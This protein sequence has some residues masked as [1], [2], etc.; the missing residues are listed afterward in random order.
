MKRVLISFMV[1]LLT[2]GVFSC[3]S[4]DDDN[5]NTNT[6]VGHWKGSNYQVYEDEN[7]S[8]LIDEGSDATYDFKFFDDGTCAYKGY[9]S[10]SSCDYK[11]LNKEIFIYYNGKYYDTYYIIEFS[12]S[13]MK[14]KY[15][16]PNNRWLV[17]ILERVS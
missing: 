11:L 5:V 6:I 14:L 3:S 15:L 17:L 12:K 2:F 7:L 1:S 16:N 10:N 8:T 4:D 13:R 9:H